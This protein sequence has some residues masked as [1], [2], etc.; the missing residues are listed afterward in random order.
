MVANLKR[1]PYYTAEQ[2]LA[3]EREADEQS[4]YL[5]GEIY[6]MA[7][8]SGLHADISMNLAG[9]LQ[10]QL[11]GTDCRARTKD[12]KV[13]SGALAEHFG[14]GLISYPDMVVICGE[15]IYH[16]HHRDVVLNPKVILEV[17]SASTEEFDR[18]AK[19]MRYRNF[20]DTLTDYVLIS[21]SE[22]YV[23]HYIRIESGEWLLREFAG[24]Q[25][26]VHIES[27]NC[28]IFLSDLYDRVN[29][30][31]FEASDNTI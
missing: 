23:E 25:A 4:F 9:T 13:R 31:T 24:L 14:R 28:S 15:P 17:L 22:A 1:K 2:Y 18:G 7:G 16:D 20:N 3:W 5:D 26:Q 6:A 11:K 27:I 21:Q 19:F 12:T 30:D 8:E 10:N 29:F